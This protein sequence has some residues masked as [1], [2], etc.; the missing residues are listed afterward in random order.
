METNRPP[1]SYLPLRKKKSAMSEDAAWA[2]LC[3]PAVVYGFLGAAGVPREDYTPY[4]SPMNFAADP[5]ARAIFLHTTIDADS[6]RS[7]CLA[8]NPRVCFTAVH[9]DAAMVH[10]GSGLA[11]K[12]SMTFTSVI[13][14]GTARAIQDPEEKARILNFFMQQKSGADNLIPV[15]PMHT[16]IA[17]VYCIDVAHITGAKKE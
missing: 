11:C 17:T 15:Q 14:L 9:P 7:Q 13:A 2:V 16:I 5:G 8:A 1:T 10:D 3:D 6:K 4:V 12:F